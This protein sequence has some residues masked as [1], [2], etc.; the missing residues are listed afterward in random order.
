MHCNSAGY[1]SLVEDLQHLAAHIE[2]SQLLHEAESAAPL[3][4][5]NVEITAND[6]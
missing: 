6:F 2:G 4:C 1:D 3:L 5:T